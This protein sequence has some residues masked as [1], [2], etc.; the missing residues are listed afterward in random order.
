MNELYPQRVRNSHFSHILLLR[1]SG[2]LEPQFPGASAS[3]SL[4]FLSGSVRAESVHSLELP[5]LIWPPRGVAPVGGVLGGWGRSARCGG[6]T[7]SYEWFLCARHTACFTL[8]DTQQ[9]LVETWKLEYL[10]RLS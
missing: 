2:A 1:G 9:P 8:G 5:Q 6:E 4:A 3:K 7:G 10:A